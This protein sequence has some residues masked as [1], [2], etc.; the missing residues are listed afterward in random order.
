MKKFTMPCLNPS[1]IM[2]GLIFIMLCLSLNLAFS[3]NMTQSILRDVVSSASI[4]EYE[5]AIK[6]ISDF[7]SE[8]EGEKELIEKVK[9]A[10]RLSALTDRL[11]DY[12][13]SD[14]GEATAWL[15]KKPGHVWDLINEEKASKT[16]YDEKYFNSLI[17]HYLSRLE[18]LKVRKVN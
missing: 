18:E 8:D 14:F 3:Q 2:K 15:S 17:E 7:K 4:G 6:L 10:I 9:I 11:T 5:N 13:G 12:Q 16:K 1:D